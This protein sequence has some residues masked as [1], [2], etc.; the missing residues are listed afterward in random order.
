MRKTLLASTMFATAT[1]GAGAASAQDSAGSCGEVS[2]AQMGWAA[3]E[4]T[5]KRKVFQ[6]IFF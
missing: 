6:A 3:A 5:T 4:V 2:I 1:L